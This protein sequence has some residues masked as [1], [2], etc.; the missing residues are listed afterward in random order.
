M[1][2][3]NSNGGTPGVTEFQGGNILVG[4]SMKLKQLKHVV[5]RVESKHMGTS[6][7]YHILLMILLM[8]LDVLSPS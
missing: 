5:E 8:I 2:E 4:D 3:V 7:I 1:L 6:S